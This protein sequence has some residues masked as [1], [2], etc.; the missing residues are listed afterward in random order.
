MGDKPTCQGHEFVGEIF[1][2]GKGVE[3][4]SMGQ[5]VKVGDRIVALIL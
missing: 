2:L 1:E 3:T 4:D 5:P